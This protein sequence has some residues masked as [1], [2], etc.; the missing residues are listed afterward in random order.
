VKKCGPTTACTA[1]SAEP[2]RKK[3]AALTIETDRERRFLFST[4]KTGIFAAFFAG[5]L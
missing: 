4:N 3:K 5:C 1:D 2:G